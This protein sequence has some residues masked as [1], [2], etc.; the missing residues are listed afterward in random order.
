MIGEP[1]DGKQLA[2]HVAEDDSILELQVSA[3]ESAVALKSWKVRQKGNDLFISARKVLVS[4][5][6]SSGEYQ[7]S[8]NTD[9]IENIYL[10]GHMIWSD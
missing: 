9:G 7:S 5:V 10:G 2:Y 4:F 6:F 1:I 3:T 8:V